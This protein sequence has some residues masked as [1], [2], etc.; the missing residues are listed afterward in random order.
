MVQPTVQKSWRKPGED[1]KKAD[2]EGPAVKSL[3]GEDA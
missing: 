2:P 3:L 1:K